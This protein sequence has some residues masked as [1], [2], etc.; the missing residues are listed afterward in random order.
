MQSY[1]KNQIIIRSATKRE[2]HTIHCSR[3]ICTY[4]FS[5]RNF[6]TLAVLAVAICHPHA[7]SILLPI[8]L[9][10]QAIQRPYPKG[11]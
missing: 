10:G 1:N 2:S 7:D 5:G 6:E 4:Q 9:A 11:L 8:W 3:R